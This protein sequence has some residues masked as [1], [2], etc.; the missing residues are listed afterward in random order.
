MAASR[1]DASSGVAEL[2][3]LGILH[4]VGRTMQHCAGRSSAYQDVKDAHVAVCLGGRASF[5]LPSLREGADAR[6]WTPAWAHSGMP[7]RECRGTRQVYSGLPKHE[8]AFGLLVPQE[9]A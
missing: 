7:R 5:T 2:A 1:S 4:Y 3:L 9:G 8:V 6:N